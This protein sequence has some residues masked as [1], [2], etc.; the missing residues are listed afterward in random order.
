MW[1]SCWIERLA[2]GAEAGADELELYEELV[3]YVLY[4]RTADAWRALMDRDAAGRP[5][6]PD[7]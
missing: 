7:G 2:A 6:P 3:L 5:R 1:I 4:A